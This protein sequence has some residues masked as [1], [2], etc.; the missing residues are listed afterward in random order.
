MPTTPQEFVP[1][2][3]ALLTLGYRKRRKFLWERVKPKLPRFLYKFRS[4]L[5]SDETSVDRLRDIL[6]RSRLWFSSPAD[7]NDPFD[8]AVKAIVDGDASTAEAS[9]CDSTG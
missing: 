5:P 2:A 4:L 9:R 8:T 6:V 7:F 1:I 3:K